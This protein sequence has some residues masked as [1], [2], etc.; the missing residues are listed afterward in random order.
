KRWVC[1]VELVFLLRLF[2]VATIATGELLG[3]FCEIVLAGLQMFCAVP[4][5]AWV[6]SLFCK[7]G[8]HVGFPAG[9]LGRSVCFGRYALGAPNCFA[10]AEL[11]A[12]AL[13]VV[14]LVL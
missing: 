10:W 11:F 8:P 2:W 12:W 3:G 13:S 1:L 4:M 5:I 9:M 7:R 14:F 6:L